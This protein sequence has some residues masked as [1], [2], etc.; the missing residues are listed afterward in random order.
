MGALRYY[1]N[2]GGEERGRDKVERE[3]GRELI[4]F[5]KVQQGDGG[6]GKAFWCTL[7]LNE[8]ILCYY[9]SANQVPTFVFLFFIFSSLFIVEF[10]KNLFVR[11]RP[12]FFSIFYFFSHYITVISRWDDPISRKH[13]IYLY[14]N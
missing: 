1:E 3:N 14:Y 11:P 10:A 2:E 4:F 6:E 9:K 12:L 8:N 7:H 5:A 13:A